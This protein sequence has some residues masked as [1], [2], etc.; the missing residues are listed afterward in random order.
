[1]IDPALFP[2]LSSARQLKLRARLEQHGENEVTFDLEELRECLD[3]PTS[4]PVTGGRRVTE[5]ELLD[6]RKSCLAAIEQVDDLSE[7]EQGQHFDLL[8]GSVLSEALTPSRGEMG[9]PRVWNFL[10]LVLLRDVA[11][12]RF[13]PARAIKTGRFDGGNRRHVFQRLWKRWVALGPELVSAGTLTEDD[14]VALFERRVTLERPAVAQRAADNILE[15]GLTGSDRRE[16]TRVLMRQLVQ[17][18]GIVAVG[19]EDHAH[20]SAL[21]S[22]LDST[23]REIVAAPPRFDA[24]IA[25]S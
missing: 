17:V 9:H 15:S 7:N 25:A 14:Y 2:R 4:Y 20:L 18:S 12:R 1:M 24:P 22:H 3:E 5:T 21:F 19:G 8:V 11:C 6:L 23:T 16:Y 10:T 13:D